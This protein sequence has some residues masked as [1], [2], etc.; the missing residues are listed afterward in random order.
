LKTN[1]AERSNLVL[2][3]SPEAHVQQTADTEKQE[4]VPNLMKAHG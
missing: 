3:Q 4:V 2:W 1:D